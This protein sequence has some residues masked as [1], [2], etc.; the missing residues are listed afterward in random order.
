MRQ[1]VTVSYF[2]DAFG[3]GDGFSYAG[4][5]ALYNHLL[6]VEEDDNQEME[7]D[8]NALCGEYSEFASLEAMLEAYPDEYGT[9]ADLR[10]YT[11]IIDI[12]GGGYIMQ[13][14]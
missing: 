14:L 5:G 7:L 11:V 13:A 6:E 12:P 4:L 10:D 1:T 2:R 8:V 9:L 3:E